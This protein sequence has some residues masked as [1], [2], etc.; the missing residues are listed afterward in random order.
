MMTVYE[1]IES[2]FSGESEE[3]P[4][5]AKEI[6]KEL[7][8]IKSLLRDKKELLPKRVNHTYT[9]QLDDDYYNFI[10]RFRISLMNDSIQGINS[11]FEYKGKKFSVNKRGLLYD[12]ENFK[13][14]SKSEAFKV[15]KYAYEHKDTSKISA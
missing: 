4:E 9:P 1:Q 6:L 15:Y 10:K 13:I 14:V 11:S 5:W 2:V 7:V 12:T 8:E 3:K